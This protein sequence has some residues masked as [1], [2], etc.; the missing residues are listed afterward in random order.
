M[1]LITRVSINHTDKAARVIG[2]DAVCAVKKFCT[3]PSEPLGYHTRWK[4][5]L[6]L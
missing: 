2:E 6:V 3:V 4:V 1:Y 5:K